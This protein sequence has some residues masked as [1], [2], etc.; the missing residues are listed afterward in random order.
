M[1]TTFSIMKL[2]F[3]ASFHVTFM[4]AN[5]F[6]LCS[7]GLTLQVLLTAKFFT[8]HLPCSHEYY[9]RSRKHEVKKNVGRKPFTSS[10]TSTNQKERKLTCKMP[11]VSHHSTSIQKKK[12]ED[13]YGFP[14]VES[15]SSE[16]DKEVLLP[17][18]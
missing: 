17:M 7:R 9:L 10:P 6:T 1:H 5:A 4:F 2:F 13:A 11:K 18:V 12:N 16:V 8:C 14:K 3:L 15:V